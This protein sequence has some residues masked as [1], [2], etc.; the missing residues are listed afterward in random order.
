MEQDAE[1]NTSSTVHHHHWF[2]STTWPAFVRHILFAFSNLFLVLGSISYIVG[3]LYFVFQQETSF[4]YPY[5]GCYLG[6]SSLFFFSSVVRLVGIACYECDSERPSQIF[7]T[8]TLATEILHLLASMLLLLSSILYMMYMINT[9]IS[10]AATYIWVTGAVMY[11]IAH[12]FGPIAETVRLVQ[13]VQE[14]MNIEWAK[15]WIGT[16]SVTLGFASSAFMVCAAI[17]S[18]NDNKYIDNIGAVFWLVGAFGFLVAG[19]MRFFADM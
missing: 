1:Q 18:V 15:R 17:L 12:V 3:S 16:S 6:G 11:L 4:S 9:G 2:T 8:L 10:S 14:E 19:M 7:R 5:R 13:T